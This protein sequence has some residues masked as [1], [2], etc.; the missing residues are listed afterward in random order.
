MMMSQFATIE[1]FLGSAEYKDIAQLVIRA[2]LDHDIGT[3]EN[4]FEQLKKKLKELKYE[5]INQMIKELWSEI[6]VTVF[7]SGNMSAN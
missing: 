7:Y 6:R 1:N 4:I 3:D 5:E 2:E